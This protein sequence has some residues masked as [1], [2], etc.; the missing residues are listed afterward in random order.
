MGRLKNKLFLGVFFSL[1]F[2]VLFV[3]PSTIFAGAWNPLGPGGG[4]PD[5]VAVSPYYNTD[6]T[7]FASSGCTVYKS[8][9]SGAGWKDVGS[10]YFTTFF[11]E[12]YFSPVYAFDGTVFALSENKLFKS[13]DSGESWTKISEGIINNNLTDTIITT[14]PWRVGVKSN[15]AG[16]FKGMVDEVSI[17][18][19]VLSESEIA[20]KQ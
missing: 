13:T 4:R 7:I 19:R 20:A 16:W 5:R 6:H 1:I 11:T 3:F 17:Y 2:S 8:T 15:N 14:A 9:N 10:G 12:I 18:N